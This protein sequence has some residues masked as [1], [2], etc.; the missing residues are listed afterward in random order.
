MPI[1]NGEA[2]PEGYWKFLHGSVR[3]LSGLL[4]KIESVTQLFPTSRSKNPK[5]RHILEA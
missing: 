3:F 5:I 1:I 2:E 4:F